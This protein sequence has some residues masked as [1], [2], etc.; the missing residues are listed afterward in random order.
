MRRNEKQITDM[1][2]IESII[3]ECRLIRVAFAGSEPYLLPFNFGYDNNRIYI[4]CAPEGKKLNLLR[5]NPK[6]AFEATLD[7]GIK[8]TDAPEACR[9]GYKYKCVL[10]SGTAVLIT[11]DEEKTHPLNVIMKHQT[12]NTSPV[13]NPE[14]LAKT[15]IIQITITSMTGKKSG[16]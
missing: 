2:E 13:Y 9:T 10:G 16:Y 6:V 3:R 15:M 5:A 11:V 8:N 7:G 1:K 14:S 12:G 4:H